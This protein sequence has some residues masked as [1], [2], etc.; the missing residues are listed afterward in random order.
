MTKERASLGERDAHGSLSARRGIDPSTIAAACDLVAEAHRALESRAASSWSA[1][2]RKILEETLDRARALLRELAR[3]ADHSGKR[4]E[5]NLP[6]PAGP[7][8]G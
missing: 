8:G 7:E 6:F 2:Q 1:E 5:E 3:L 4:I